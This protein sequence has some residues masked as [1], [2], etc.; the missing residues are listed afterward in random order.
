MEDDVCECGEAQ[1]QRHIFKF[2]NFKEICTETWPMSMIMPETW[3]DSD[4]GISFIDR[5]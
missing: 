2:S 1:D 3:K 5:Y 4:I